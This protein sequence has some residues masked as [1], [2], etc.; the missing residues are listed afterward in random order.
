MKIKLFIFS[1]LFILSL[2]INALASNTFLIYDLGFKTSN[3]GQITINFKKANHQ[4]S[5]SAIS[6][7]LGPL[8]IIGEHK[9]LAN[10][11]IKND[12]LQTRAIQ[13]LN[14]KKNEV[15]STTQIN[16]EKQL[17]VIDKKNK[18]KKYLL[19]ENTQDILTHL[20]EFNTELDSTKKIELNIAD[21]IGYKKFTYVKTGE[22]NIK[23]NN[24]MIKTIKYDGSV[25]E[26]KSTHTLWVA[27]KNHIPIKLVVKTRIGV[28]QINLSDTN[29]TEHI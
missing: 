29:I 6:K 13:R 17:I 26:K 24:Q 23:V 18:N 16:Y 19:R 20:F 25:K 8:K 9:V 27:K 28:I 12:T 11:I 21:T 7:F 3:L 5:I 22:E 1:I 4:Y 14:L 10:G 2:N 15:S